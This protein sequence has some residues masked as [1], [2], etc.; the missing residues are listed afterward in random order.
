MIELP[1]PPGVQRRVIDTPMGPVAALHARPAGTASPA[2][3][4]SPAS[5]ASP[6]S[7]ANTAG[8]G[9]VVADTGTTAVMTS[10]FFGTK[11]D[12]RAVL[13]LFAAAGY[14]GWAYDYPGQLGGRH[15]TD[16]SSY[17]IG[18]M[19][20]ELC[21]IIQAVSGGRPVHL[22]GHCLGG[23]VAREAVLAMPALARSLTLLA[24]GPS[25]REAKHRVMLEGLA[26]MQKKGGTIT[27]WP[28]VKRLLA[29]DD[30]V[31]REFWHSKL[32]EMNPHFVQGAAQSM[33]EEHDRSAELIAAGVRSL[34]VRGKRDKRLWSPGTYA[35]MA[36]TLRADLI[37]IDNAAHS[38]NMEQPAP[39]ASALLGFWA[40][41]A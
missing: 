12:F 41:L 17:T 35:E 1:L 11:E 20:T 15:G 24:C 26:A 4:V 38:P 22:V 33:G 23:F 13:P 3:T 34:V 40:G 39:T 25:M 10:G 14:E 21:Q 28:M 19:A 29:E 30:V 8:T 16:P 9:D 2:S 31:M 18:R 7:T 37:V 5:T 6:V 36:R 32:A 27:L